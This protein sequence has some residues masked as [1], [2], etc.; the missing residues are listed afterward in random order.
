MRHLRADL[1]RRRVKR[2]EDL[3][4]LKSGAQVKVAGLVIGRQRPETASGVTFITLEDETG[5]VNLIVHRKIFD[6]QYRIARHAEMVLVSGKVERD[7]DVIH[8]L[9]KQF[10]K[11]SLPMAEKLPTRSR[12]FH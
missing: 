8:V 3:R 7:G 9:A 12:D 2:A 5:L 6:E 11:L 4:K 1:Q 10:E